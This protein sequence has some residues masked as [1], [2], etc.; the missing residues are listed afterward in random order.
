M[1]RVFGAISVATVLLV[2]WTTAHAMIWQ[3]GDSDCDGSYWGCREHLLDDF[4][5]SLGLPWL[6][7][8]AG[9]GILVRIWK[10]T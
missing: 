3:M 4:M 9:V 8:L 10:R 6:L 7:W 2:L 5:L 1:S